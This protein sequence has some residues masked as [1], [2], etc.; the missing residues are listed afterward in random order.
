MILALHVYLSDLGSPA[1]YSHDLPHC[2]S[3]MAIVQATLAKL[4]KATTLR[5]Q[6]W[7]LEMLLQA[8]SGYPMLLYSIVYAVRRS[9]SL[10][11]G[12]PDVQS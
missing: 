11:P 5:G 9:G 4:G 6:V 10:L 3:V 7:L 12:F 8:V 1:C 2:R